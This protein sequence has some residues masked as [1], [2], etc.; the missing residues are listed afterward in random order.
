[1]VA[2]FKDFLPISAQKYGDFNIGL[3]SYDILDNLSV[4]LKSLALQM[5][6]L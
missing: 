2:V 6:E 1:M 4:Y 3:T 5:K